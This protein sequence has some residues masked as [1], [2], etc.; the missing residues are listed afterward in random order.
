M[1]VPVR[2]PVVIGANNPALV[3]AL[4]TAAIDF[5]P[6]TP[7]EQYALEDFVALFVRRLIY[8]K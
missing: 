5:V 7:K 8:Y 2:I 4:A 1:L 3:Q 6:M